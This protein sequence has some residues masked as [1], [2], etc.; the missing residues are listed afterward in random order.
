MLQQS[1]VGKRKSSVCS[2][3]QAVDTA[4]ANAAKE[5]ARADALVRAARKAKKTRPGLRELQRLKVACVLAWCRPC[6]NTDLTS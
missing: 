2:I 5:V 1:E 4:S 6:I 3:Q